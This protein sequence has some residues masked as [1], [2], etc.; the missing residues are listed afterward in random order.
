MTPAW[1]VIDRVF[2]NFLGEITVLVTLYGI[3]NC[4]T[5]K[6]AR[7]WLDAHD[8]DYHYHDFRKDGLDSGLLK[9][10]VRELGWEALLNKRG[11]TWRKLP[12]QEKADLDEARA[13]S[14][15]VANPA[16]IKRPVLQHDKKHLLGFTPAAYQEALG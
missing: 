8:I 6:K 13:I 5:V 12:E 16:I 15:M 3:R 4:D 14:L 11:T 7:L 9:A 2:N 1:Q 10:W